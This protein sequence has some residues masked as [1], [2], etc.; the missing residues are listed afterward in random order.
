MEEALWTFVCPPGFEPTN[1]A[2]ERG[3]RPGI[4]WQQ[5]SYG[6]QSQQGSE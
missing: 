2:A 6:S 1:N 4:L 3:F 5:T